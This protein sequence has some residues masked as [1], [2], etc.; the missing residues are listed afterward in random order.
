MVLEYYMNFFNDLGT[1]TLKGVIV[2]CR[3]LMVSVAV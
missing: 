1:E 3:V 2:Y